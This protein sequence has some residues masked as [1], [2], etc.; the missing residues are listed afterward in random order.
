LDWIRLD[1]YRLVGLYLRQF[2][3]TPTNRP[4][5]CVYYPTHSI[6]RRLPPLPRPTI[7]A[8]PYTPFSTFEL[9]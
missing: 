3:P 4:A 1:Y 9:D 6:F 8:L 2:K 5:R 7:A